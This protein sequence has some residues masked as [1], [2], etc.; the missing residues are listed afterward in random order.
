MKNKLLVSVFALGLAAF[1]FTSCE[2]KSN[3]TEV[4]TDLLKGTL[5]GVAAASGDAPSATRGFV[6]IDG[7]TLLLA[8]YEFPSKD[9]NDSRLLYRE[10]AF[11][12]GSFA[13]KKVDTLSY[14]YGEWQDQNTVFTLLVTPKAGDPYTL[15]YR[16]DA[17]I[18]PDGRAFGGSTS[19]SSAR[20]EKL[21][22]VIGTFP[23][24]DWEA[25]FRGEFVTD[26]IFRDSIKVTF[27]P[28]MSFKYDTIKVFDHMDTVSADTTCYYKLIFN[29]EPGTFANTGHYYRKQ[30]RSTYDRETKETTIVSE[31]VN[32]YE[33]DFRWMFSDLATDAKF[34]VQ[35]TNT[36]QPGVEG[37]KLSIARYTLDSLGV[38]SEFALGGLTYKRPVQP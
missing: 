4:C 18:A 15:K 16:G 9:V 38:A 13:P 22:K 20:V 21:E 23:N 19:L 30:F 29:R 34:T 33:Y 28:P 36:S 11:G 26:S 12:D 37:E 17:L 8:E 7:S 27:I 35:L 24:T 31:S 1:A 6:K 5:H 14:E 32:V 25:T 3:V 10:I 2:T